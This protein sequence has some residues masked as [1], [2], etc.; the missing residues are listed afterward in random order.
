[1]KTITITLDGDGMNI[2]MAASLLLTETLQNA[3]KSG[4]RI[5]KL[6]MLDMPQRTG[7][8]NTMNIQIPEFLRRQR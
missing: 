4:A 8:P 1:M 2:E 6:E 7:P 3:A 5:A